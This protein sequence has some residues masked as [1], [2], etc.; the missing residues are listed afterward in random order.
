MNV[1][2]V[3]IDPQNDFCDPKGSLFVPGA[4]D[5][6]TRIA[7]MIHRLSNRI[8]DIHVTMDSHRSIDIAHPIFWKDKNG[9]HP[10]PFTV[11]SVDDVEKG[12]WMPSL[13]SFS[14]WALEYVRSLETN[15]RY[16]LCIW[17]PHCIIGSWGHAINPAVSDALI[18][19]ETESFAMVDYV[20]KGSNI[21]TEHYSAVQAE[22]VRGDDPSTQLNTRLIDA[23]Q[24]ADVIGLCGEALSHCLANTVRDIANNFGD[25]NV[26]K[27]VLLTDGCSNVTSFEHLGESFIKDLTARG[28]KISTTEDFLK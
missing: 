21:T 8:D 5:D 26:K 6:M 2:L 23:L 10:N 1:Q 18:E 3:C 14:K 12:R 25:D 15:H 9:N 16:V 4:Q 13:P 27:L 24:I 17:P 19:W 20:V 28:M 22:V 7:K 11:I